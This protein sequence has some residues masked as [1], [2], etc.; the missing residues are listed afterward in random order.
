MSVS[1]GFRR[2]PLRARPR[3]ASRARV[4]WAATASAGQHQQPAQRAGLGE[5]DRDQPG[6]PEQRRAG[7][8]PRVE[9]A[10]REQDERHD[11]RERGQRGEQRQQRGQDRAVQPDRARPGRPQRERDEARQPRRAARRARP[12]PRGRWRRSPR[13][14]RGSGRARAAPR[15]AAASRS[16]R[17]HLPEALA[18]QVRVVGQ[19]LAL[20]L[21]QVDAR[22]GSGGSSGAAGRPRSPRG[23]ASTQP[24]FSSRSSAAYSVPARRRTRPS[25]ISS[26][27]LMIP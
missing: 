2:H 23:R 1:R 27:A 5:V 21:E 12:R 4:T 22:P 20:G 13:R 17:P 9:D 7:R 24:A 18:D 25:D 10:E 15:R 3:G 6:Q 19:A 14:A 26:T 8:Q 16:R 11:E